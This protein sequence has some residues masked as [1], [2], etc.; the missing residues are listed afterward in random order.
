MRLRSSS[1]LGQN[2]NKLLRIFVHFLLKKLDF[3]IVEKSK[4]NVIK[5]GLLC[6]VFFFY[7]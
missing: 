4:I 5:S 1:D 3:S 6:C 7:F 2:R